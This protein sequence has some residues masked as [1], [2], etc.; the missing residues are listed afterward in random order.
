ML[1]VVDRSRVPPGAGWLW[2]D[3]FSVR[4]EIVV[5]GTQYRKHGDKDRRPGVLS[6]VD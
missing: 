4:K 2:L 1:S 5:S 6:G 3:A